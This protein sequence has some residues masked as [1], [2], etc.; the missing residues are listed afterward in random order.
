MWH[1]KSS[2]F[3][4]HDGEKKHERMQNSISFTRFPWF[5]F[6]HTRYVVCRLLLLESTSLFFSKIALQTR[7]KKESTI[8][9]VSSLFDLCISLTIVCWV[10]TYRSALRRE[11]A[12]LS[13]LPRM[14][15][16]LTMC[17]IIQ[18]LV[19]LITQFFGH[20]HKNRAYI[21]IINFL[22]R[23]DYIETTKKSLFLF[24]QMIG[25]CY[26]TK[27][28]VEC[29][30]NF[31]RSALALH[32][33]KSLVSWCNRRGVYTFFFENSICIARAT[34]SMNVNAVV[35][36]YRV[37]FVAVQCINGAEYRKNNTHSD[38]NTKTL[39]GRASEKS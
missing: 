9:N 4:T 18:S 14:K 33:Q 23:L 5:L 32:R 21:I 26:C 35:V 13:I 28:L 25:C 36:K 20:G 7:W 12:P 34:N 3:I 22:C 37:A 6:Y 2:A 19:P 38:A 31:F 8:N 24:T 15:L 11:C 17:T 16:A 30:V 29:L 10:L 39:N 1:R 27:W